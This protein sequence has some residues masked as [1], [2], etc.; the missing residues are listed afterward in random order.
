MTI[1]NKQQKRT[2]RH[3]RVRA[4]VSGTALRPRLAVFKSNKHLSAQL[5]DDTKGTTLVASSDSAIAGSAKKPMREVATLIGEDIAK[6]AKTAKIE[7]VVF[8]TGG[9]AYTGNISALAEG[10]RK[11]G[12][13]F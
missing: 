5:I 10:A 13:I 3:A 6:K 1:L 11:G 12:L 4:K 7:T 2:R 8:D 9:F